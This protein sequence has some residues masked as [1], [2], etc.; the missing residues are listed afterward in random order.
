M[1][2]IPS[3]TS[4]VGMHIRT[5]NGINATNAMPDQ[6]PTGTEA[7]VCKDITERQKFGLTKYGI[8]VEANPLPLREWLQHAYLETIDHAIYLKRAINEIDKGN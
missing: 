2:S 4:A 1:G 5:A 8:S 7:E 3:S 6:Q